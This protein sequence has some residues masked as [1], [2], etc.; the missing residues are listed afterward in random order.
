MIEPDVA[1]KI[2]E[3]VKGLNLDADDDKYK[4]FPWHGAPV[5]LSAWQ[6]TFFS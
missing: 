2:F 3:A 4:S 5:L 6:L 1:I